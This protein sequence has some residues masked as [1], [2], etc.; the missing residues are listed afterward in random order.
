MNY[1]S[2]EEVKLGDIVTLGN[3]NPGVVVCSLDTGEYSEKYSHDQW[4]Y[5]KQGVLIEFMKFGIIHYSNILE[6]DIVLVSRK[7]P[8]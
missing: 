5:L 8:T 6:H 3:N 7:S 2:G 1:S 4:S